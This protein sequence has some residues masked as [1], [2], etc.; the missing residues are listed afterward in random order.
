MYRDLLNDIC[1]YDNR[2]RKC[3]SGPRYCSMTANE[4]YGEIIKILESVE[5]LGYNFGGIFIRGCSRTVI[6]SSLLLGVK[7]GT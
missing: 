1:A 6:N 7:W 3:L 5:I 2:K 4:F